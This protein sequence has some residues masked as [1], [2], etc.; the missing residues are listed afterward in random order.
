MC[1]GRRRERQQ[2]SQELAAKEEALV[3]WGEEG[4]EGGGEGRGKREGAWAHVIMPLFTATT[5]EAG[6]GS[7]GGTSTEGE[8]GSAA[9]ASEGQLHAVHSAVGSCWSISL[10][11]LHLFL[12]P[13]IL[14]AG[15]LCH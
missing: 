3:G 5:A 13:V 10:Q 12:L 1:V 11:W 14:L 15:V 4:E 9:T 2:H 8:G 6:R 7:S